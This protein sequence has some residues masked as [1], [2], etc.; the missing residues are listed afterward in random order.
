[1]LGCFLHKFI[2]SDYVIIFMNVFM[3]LSMNTISKK[4]SWI[5]VF[6]SIFTGDKY[7][8]YSRPNSKTTFNYSYSSKAN[9][10]CF[11]LLSMWNINTNSLI[12][13]NITYLFSLFSI[14]NLQCLSTWWVSIAW[15]IPFLSSYKQKETKSLKVLISVFLKNGSC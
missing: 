12:K 5:P 2:S 1:M 13:T 4:Y 7:F 9:E 3:I 8:L 15:V 11:C 10:P 14:F 6:M